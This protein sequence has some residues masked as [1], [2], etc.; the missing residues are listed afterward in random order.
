M[1]DPLLLDQYERL[2]DSLPAA[3]PWPIL[4]ESGFLDLLRPEEEGGAGLTLS[5]LLPLVLA[6]AAR[7]SPPK[8]VE[9]MIARLLAPSTTN[10]QDLEAT[11]AGTGMDPDRA[12]ALAA[13]I[14][15]AQMAGAVLKLQQMTTEY[16]L[17][18]RQFGRTIGSFQAVQHQIAMLAE[19]AVACRATARAAFVGPPLELSVRTAA[20]A[21]VR[22]GQA[23]QVACAVAHAVHGAIGISAEYPLH[24]YTARLNAWRLAHGGEAY[25]ARRLGD[26]I[27][28]ESRDLTSLVRT[29]P[30]TAE[31]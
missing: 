5:D 17:T 14:A 21:K 31:A 29:L 10:V 18:R 27:V 24:S 9:T 19:E 12:R 3:D 28:E 1:S 25:W 6:T 15:A 20:V 4:E 7:S 26:W 16:A 30:S 13:A 23:A 8:I 22:S 2:L 11:L